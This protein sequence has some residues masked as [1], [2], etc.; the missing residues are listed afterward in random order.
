[1]VKKSMLIS[2][3][4][5]LV[6]FF[7]AC[8]NVPTYNYLDATKGKGFVVISV[9]V[10]GEPIDTLSVYWRGVDNNYKGSI[11]GTNIFLKDDWN[12]SNSWDRITED[13]FHGRLAVIELPQGEYE[14][15]AHVAQLDFKEVS[16]IDTEDNEYSK[17]FEVIAG[18]AV[19]VGNMH[20]SFEKKHKGGF[21]FW[22]YLWKMEI[23]DMQ[24][25]DLTL[26]YQRNPKITPDNVAVNII[27]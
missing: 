16:K 8:Q 23:D 7:T 25:R 27:Q 24:E 1:M 18:K 21:A 19:Y 10:S 17:R 6:V 13:N 11:A 5:L 15:Y 9:T 22:G 14:F 26:F 20:F 2:L 3:F 12:E 4:G